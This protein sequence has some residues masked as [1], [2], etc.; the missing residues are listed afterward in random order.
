MIVNTVTE[1]VYFLF[2][3]GDKDFW[4]INGAGNLCYIHPAQAGIRNNLNLITASG[5]VDSFLLE[6]ISGAPNADANQRRTGDQPLHSTGL[7]CRLL[8]ERG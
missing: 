8:A 3:T 1:A 7:E 6:E 4:I 5:H 2:A